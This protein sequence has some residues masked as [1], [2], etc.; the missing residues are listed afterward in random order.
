MMAL[1]VVQTVA[2]CCYCLA[3]AVVVAAGAAAIAVQQE[4]PSLELVS[5]RR[6]II[7]ISV[8]LSW[9]YTDLI[10]TAWYLD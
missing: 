10:T 4:V 5:P 3:P 8:I 1:I 6:R 2:S 7:I 9:P